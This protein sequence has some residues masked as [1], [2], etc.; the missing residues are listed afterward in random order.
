MTSP[1]VHL[2]ETAYHPEKKTRRASQPLQLFIEYVLIK[3]S[4]H[5]LYFLC[6]FF[7]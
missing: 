6:D 4:L 7:N 1:H 3:V 5:R 2:S